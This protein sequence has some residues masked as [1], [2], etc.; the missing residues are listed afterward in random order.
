MHCPYCTSEISDAALVCPVC[1]RDLYLF[2]PLLAR[3]EKLE[4]QDAA[5]AD[6]RVRALEE[7]IAG[8]E[9]ELQQARATPL[10]APVAPPQA[11]RSY[12]LSAL[13]TGLAALLL[14]LLAHGLIIMV[15]D[16]KPM[17]LRV[18]S[19]L[20]PLPFGFA[21][22]ARHPQ[23][24]WVSAGFGV[25]LALAAV[26]GMSAVT[27]YVD[28][29]PVL[30]QDMRDVRELVEYT[31]SIFFSLATGMLLARWML[32]RQQAA[33]HASRLA[34]L[35]AKVLAKDEQGR[36]DVQQTMER[37][38]ALGAS[39]APLGTAAVSIYTGIKS[40]LGDSS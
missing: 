24:A 11:P 10:P 23:R 33:Q 16:L 35:L 26:F 36:L 31:A 12:L 32:R 28:Q 34:A 9:Q 8:L 25:L 27:G 4:Q 20:I 13:L 2:K 5:Q 17:Y 3:I 22:L 7:R 21:L 19:L 39:L 1:T 37:L 29:V 15:Y 14:L 40:L 18:A 38:M 6:A 30:P